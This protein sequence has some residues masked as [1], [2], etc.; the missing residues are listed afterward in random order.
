MLVTLKIP[1]KATIRNRTSTMASQF[2]RA[3]A[4]YI[5]PTS[6]ELFQRCRLLKVDPSR[7][8][9]VY[10][11]ASATEWDHLMPM[12][13]GAAWTGFFTEIANLVP[14]C[15]KCNQS[16]GSKPVAKWMRSTARWAPLTVFRIRDGL[17]LN[18]ASKEVDRRIAVIENAMVEQPPRKLEVLDHPLEA[19][20][21]EKRLEMNDLLAEAEK[22]A[23]ELRELY[24]HKVAR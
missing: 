19:K 4:P 23:S 1:G 21:E 10:C 20:L 16:R 13:Q 14:A 3:R 2:A 8:D 15:G 12:V 9:C 5:L 11:G 18:R 22:V 6:D 7:P 17:S 24:R